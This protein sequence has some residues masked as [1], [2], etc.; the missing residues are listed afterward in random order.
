[1]TTKNINTEKAKPQDDKE[2]SKTLIHTN[3]RIR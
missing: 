3:Y 1:M 2:M